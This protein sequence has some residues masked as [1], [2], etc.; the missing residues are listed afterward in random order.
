MQI[1]ADLSQVRPE[2]SCLI[3]GF[4]DGVHRGH[5]YLIGQASASARRQGLRAVLITFYPHPSVVLRGAEPFHLS[6][7]EEK[8]DL[9][10]ALDLDLIIIEPFTLSFGQTRASQFVDQLITQIG[11]VELWVGPNFAMGYR[12]EGDVQF[13]RQLG[14]ERAFAVNV[15]NRLKLDGAPISS[16][17]IREALR[18]GN[19]T[20]AARCLGRPYS[21]QGQVVMGAQRGRSLG[22]PTANIAVSTEQAMPAHGVY[23]A[24]ARLRGEPV[25]SRDLGELAEVTRQDQSERSANEQHRAVINIGTHPTF[26]TGLRTV[27][28]HL[29]DFDRDIYGQHMIID[30]VAHLR[31]ERRFNGAETLADQIAHDVAQARQ[32][33]HDV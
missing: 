29:L 6:S 19:V 27:G 13:L 2:P 5:V 1:L 32:L 11:M 18:E 24:W 21:L 33:L 28:A 22:F 14:E 30:F 3:V 23:A 12:R 26:D 17:R 31:S 25:M 15:V 8:L 20:L 9:L 7:R 10:S 4:F 16:S